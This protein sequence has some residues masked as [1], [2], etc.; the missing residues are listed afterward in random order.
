MLGQPGHDLV[1]HLDEWPAW[2]PGLQLLGDPVDPILQ[3]L[4]RPPAKQAGQDYRTRP[5][6]ERPATAAA[7]AT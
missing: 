2:M 7:K 1:A 6:G 4:T 3:V 5:Q